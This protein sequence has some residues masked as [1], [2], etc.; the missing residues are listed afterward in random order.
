MV[1]RFRKRGERAGCTPDLAPLTRS[2]IRGVEQFQTSLLP[3]IR[4]SVTMM[5]GVG[6]RRRCH[7][8]SWCV[9]LLS[10]CLV[11]ATAWA[12]SQRSMVSFTWSALP[13]LKAR[14]ISC[15]HGRASECLDANL[16]GLLA[17][18]IRDASL[19]TLEVGKLRFPNGGDGCLIP[20]SCG[21]CTRK[22]S[23]PR[24]PASSASFIVSPCQN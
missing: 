8:P 24:Y 7:R 2:R 18:F 23:T 1:H 19:A 6:R 5:T 12:Y 3:S 21:V 14:R 11:L 17:R 4:V 13:I 20:G 9:K 22:Q 16:V 10:L 15:R